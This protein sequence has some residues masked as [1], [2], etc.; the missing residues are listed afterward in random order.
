ME[1]ADDAG[2]I[3][4]ANQDLYERMQRYYQDGVDK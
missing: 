4:G 3:E 2:M 1:E